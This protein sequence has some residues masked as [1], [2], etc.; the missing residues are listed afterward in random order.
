MVLKRRWKVVSGTMAASV[1][2]VPAAKAVTSDD[3]ADDAPTEVISTFEFDLR[4]ADFLS[5]LSEGLPVSL[6]FLGIPS[7]DTAASPAALE[8]A[9]SAPTV[10]SPLSVDTPESPDS[11]DSP[12]SPQSPDTPESPDTPD[13]P[14]SPD[15]PDTPQTVESAQTAD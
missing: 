5:R 14:E 12:D 7:V 13:T 11:P 4:E 8:T 10:D 3:T 9:D 6:A 15:T 1:A 2:I